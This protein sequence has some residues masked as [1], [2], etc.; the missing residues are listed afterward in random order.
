MKKGQKKPEACRV[1]SLFGDPENSEVMSIAHALFPEDLWICTQEPEGAAMCELPPEL[2]INE[3]G[4]ALVC[5]GHAKRMQRI[6]IQCIADRARGWKPLPLTAKEVNGTFADLSAFSSEYAKSSQRASQKWLEI[7]MTGASANE[8]GGEQ[9]SRVREY[10]R[11]SCFILG[12]S[13]VN[14]DGE[15]LVFLYFPC[16]QAQA[17]VSVDWIDGVHVGQS[18]SLASQA[19]DV[20]HQRPD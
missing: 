8:L 6:A 9:T 19:F 18:A 5:L 20:D 13:E 14:R 7:R 3:D 16:L 1:K 2:G 12:H 10:I 17:E 11:L 4:E 15:Q